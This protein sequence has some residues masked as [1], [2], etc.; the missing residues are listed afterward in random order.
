MGAKAADELP[1]VTAEGGYSLALDELTLV[2]RNAKGT[3]L[4]SVPAELRKGETAEQLLALRDWLKQHEA[5]CRA[6]VESWML[7]SLP[8]ARSAIAAVC[9]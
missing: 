4:R 5:E 3:R 9:A 6:L 2:A 8:I 1:W 7:R